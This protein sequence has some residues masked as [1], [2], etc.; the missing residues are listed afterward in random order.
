MRFWITK[1]RVPCYEI[2]KC[3]LWAKQKPIIN[4]DGLYYSNLKS[5]LLFWEKEKIFERIFGKLKLGECKEVFF[6]RLSY[7]QRKLDEAYGKG[8]KKDGQNS[9]NQSIPIKRPKA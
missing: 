3:G 1:N 7:E 5:K 6:S 2:L 9:R 4:A 8:C